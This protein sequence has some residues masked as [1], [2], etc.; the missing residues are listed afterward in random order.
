MK[1][2]ILGT[3]YKLK[4]NCNVSDYSGLLENEAYTDFTTKEIIIGDYDTENTNSIKNL[5]YHIRKVKRHEIIHSLLYESGL[6]SNTDWATN[7]EI[8]DWIAIQY[9]KMKE[10][11]SKL[12]I[13]S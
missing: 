6:D 7:E 12:N 3:N 9:P 10:I 5:K 11:F 2:N 8:I 1:I 13:E 4:E